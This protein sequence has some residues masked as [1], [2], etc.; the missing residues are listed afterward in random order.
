M[1]RNWSRRFAYFALLC[2]APAVFA[3]KPT[4]PP[5]P[6]DPY[7]AL[8]RD[9]FKQLIEINTTDSVG[10]ITEASEAMAKRFRE[11][12]FPPADVRVVGPNDRKKNL[13]VRLRG[14][15]KHK[16]ILMI[17]HLDVVEAR[18]EDWTTNPFEFVEKDGYF[19]GRGTQDMKHGDA[20]MATA[21]LRLKKENYVPSRDLILALTADEEGGKS[22]GV[23]W[24][25]KNQRALVDA[26][27]VLNHDGY[28]V[29]AEGAKPVVYELTSSEKVYADYLLTSTN[30]GG[31]SS[32]PTPDNA[33]YELLEGLGRLA[34]Y[35]FPFEL[36]NITRGY[37]AS[38]SKIETG[39]RAADMRAIL[40][41]PPDETAIKRL[42]QDPTDHSIMRT[43]CVATR[44]EAGHANNALPQR[45]QATVNCRILPGHSPDEVRQEIIKVLA[46]P[47]IRVQFISNEGEVR[48]TATDRKGFPP[49]PLRPELMR[50]LEKL[51]SEYWPGLQIVPVMA[52]G[53]SDDVY[54]NDA[55]LTSYTITGVTLDRND[56]RAHGQ[57]ERLP[58]QSFYTGNEFFYRYLKAITE[59]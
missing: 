55:G 1:A 31:H 45:A 41:T 14:A 9:I 25:F 51:V 53:A 21:L 10:S 47:K 40:K 18:R 3:A 4:P 42:S 50:P 58:V 7:N 38:L 23:D 12:G 48:D 32:R 20:I 29:Q 36:N 6:N 2:A 5:S 13:V 56:D 22:N 19:Y 30:P 54:V 37:Y 26:E 15:E 34:K 52:I 17:G 44:L 8:A 28:S 24:L 46:S 27:F 57:D 33:I 39:Q 49:P 16:P 35:E 59:K 43:T 11:A